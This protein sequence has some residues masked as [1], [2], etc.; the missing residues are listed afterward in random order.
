MMNNE[1]RQRL[2]SKAGYRLATYSDPEDMITHAICDC[3][4]IVPK[5]V[6]SHICVW[7]QLVPIGEKTK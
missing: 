4:M 6:D 5:D 2:A 7:T 1:T 3:G